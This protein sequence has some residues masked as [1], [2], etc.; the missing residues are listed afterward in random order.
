VAIII[1]SNVAFNTL[2]NTRIELLSENVLAMHVLSANNIVVSKDRVVINQNVALGS[3]ITVSTITIPNANIRYETFTVSGN[4]SVT[5]TANMANVNL[6]G[7]A[8]LQVDQTLNI[9]SNVGLLKNNMPVQPWVLI[10]A[11]A[12]SAA[13]N[14]SSPTLT[15]WKAIRVRGSNITVSTDAAVI[16]ARLS[17]NDGASFMSNAASYNSEYWSGTHGVGQNISSI[18]LTTSG[19][20]SGMGNVATDGGGEFEFTFFGWDTA[21]I[22]PL[23]YFGMNN[24]NSTTPTQ[25]GNM[26]YGN[27]VEL[28]AWNKFQFYASVGTFTGTLWIEG[29]K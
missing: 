17:V 24:F 15:G 3:N 8:N 22:T 19:S 13:T 9:S 5:G 10:N 4:L 2:Q 23:S 11:M 14:V 26:F 29:M 16:R 28:G 7:S 12:V 6:A 20:L 25:S 27:I 1:A 21:N 18:L